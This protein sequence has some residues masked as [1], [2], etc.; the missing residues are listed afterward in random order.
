LTTAL[1]DRPG[2]TFGL[3]LS[4]H[5]RS[6]LHTLA[7]RL[8]LTPPA[9]VDDA[10]WVALARTASCQLPSRL[11]EA[12]RSFRHDPGID[13]TLT[14]SNLPVAAD[15][16]PTPTVKDSV[17]RAATIAATTAM[18]LG[19]QLGEVISYRDEKR[20]ALVQNVIPVRSLATTQSNGG[21]VPLELHTENAFHPHRPDYVGLL[22]LRPAHQD[23]VG[24]QVA[25]I[26]RALPLL[27]D[28]DVTTL[29]EPRFCTAAPPSFRSAD[30]SSPSA[31]LLGDGEDP[32]ICVDFHATTALDDKAAQALSRLRDALVEVRT[33]LVLRPGDMVFVD[34]R[35]VVHGRVAFTPRYDGHDRWLHRVFVH[36][37]PRRSRP[38]RPGNGSVL[39]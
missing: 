22:C 31:V 4:E 12:I 16:P 11:I 36:L 10:G 17:E 6:D 18:L 14:I 20:G 33:D 15:L 19:Q 28:A 24:T 32:D 8:T 39:V 3:A 27:D 9:L 7:E 26:R 5:E 34:N 23:R 1:T 37:D 29:R 35:L 13:G 21:S 2:E 38:S 30:S 25:A